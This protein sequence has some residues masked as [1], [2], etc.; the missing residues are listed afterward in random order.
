M[1]ATHR[2]RGP[3]DE[4]PVAAGEPNPTHNNAKCP[5]PIYGIQ[6]LDGEVDVS[7]PI[8]ARYVSGISD[9]DRAI[10]QVV[11]SLATSRLLVRPLVRLC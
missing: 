2:C 6:A 3:A 8:T 7:S 5:T 4:Q 1:G 11:A 10:D 9:G